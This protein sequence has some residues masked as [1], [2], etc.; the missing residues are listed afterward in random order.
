MAKINVTLPNRAIPEW[1]LLWPVIVEFLSVPVPDTDKAIAGIR[2]AMQPKPS[3]KD[4]EALAK[5]IGRLLGQ[6]TIPT[7]WTKTAEDILLLVS[8]ETAIAIT[9]VALK[10]KLWTAI[11]INID[12]LYKAL[13]KGSLS[14]EWLEGKQR[15]QHLLEGNKGDEPVQTDDNPRC[16]HGRLPPCNHCMANPNCKRCRGVGEF[17]E[18]VDGE[19]KIVRCPLCFEIPP[20]ESSPTAVL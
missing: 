13:K 18:S 6:K 2:A 12:R 17:N 16:K 8:A 4:A 19:M 20:S 15:Q 11:I 10:D 5:N 3:S 1:R 7:T 9:E 14:L